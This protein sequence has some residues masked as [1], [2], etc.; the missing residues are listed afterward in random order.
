MGGDEKEEDVAAAALQPLRQPPE[1]LETIF[2]QHHEAVFR[3][4]YRITGDAMDA[5]DVLQTVFVRLLRR[6]GEREPLDPTDGLSRYLH[7]AAVNAALDLL[8]GRK[9]RPAVGLDEVAD[10]LAD[11][12][13]IGPDRR[14]HS[15][16]LRTRLREA[17]SRL[18]PRA[19]EIFAMRYFEG[20]GNLEIARLTGASQTAVAVL[21]HRAR[22]RL[23]KE[24]APLQGD[25]S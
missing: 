3:A 10:D 25:L 7:R 14:R 12:A 5:E 11:T 22:H 18:S 21:L 16:E 6:D 13:D 9:R 17:L 2:R 8:R 1:A 19:A 23:Q 24:L 20:F 4:A 15:Q